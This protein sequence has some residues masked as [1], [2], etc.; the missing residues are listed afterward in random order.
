MALIQA[1]RVR[2]TTTTTGTG[3]VTLAGAVVGFRAFSSVMA[4]NDVCHYVISGGS[5]WEVGIGTFV[6]ATPALARTTVLAS[7]NAGSLVSF[8]AGTKDVF[9]SAITE[10]LVLPEMT[11]DPA[12]PASGDYFYTRSLG[13]RFVPRWIGPS[14][15]DTAVQP[16]MFANNV[17]MWLPGTGTT[18]AINFGAAWTVDA[19][20]AHPTIANTNF[21]TQMKRATFT[22][23]TTSGNASGTRS[24]APICWRGN[25]AGQG[26]FFYA[27]RGGVLTF[28][29]AMAIWFGLSGQTTI[30]AANP[31]A[32][33]DTVCFGKDHTD[34]NWQA[35]VRSTTAATKTDSGR[36]VAAATTSNIFDFYFFCKPNDSQITFRMVDV[37]DGTVLINNVS[38]TTNLPT[39]TTMLTAHAAVRAGSAAAVAIFLNKIYIESDT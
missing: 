4:N 31:S 10:R 39:N 19:T 1:D 29:S 24:S 15:L 21:M 11:S 33:N 12:P 2:E 22:T 9:I 3:N 32:T 14:G 6:S 7:S 35:I 36:A 17:T 38:V 16:A 37:T 27:A 23:T 26:G 25:A 5:E 18:A 8:S 30:L 20:Q 34:T 28:Q 13:G